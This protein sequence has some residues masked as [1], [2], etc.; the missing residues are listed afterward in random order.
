MP[1]NYQVGDGS[2]LY[3]RQIHPMFIPVALLALKTGWLDI[4]GSLPQA[5]NDCFKAAISV[6]P[7]AG[8][9]RSAP[10]ADGTVPH[11]RPSTHGARWRI[12]DTGK[13]NQ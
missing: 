2:V 6:G 1:S 10:F 12:A 9:G 7:V 11:R 4:A 13:R 8:H 5:A 3:A